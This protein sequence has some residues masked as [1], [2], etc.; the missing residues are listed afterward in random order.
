MVNEKYE[1]LKK[2]SKEYKKEIKSLLKNKT[3]NR[4]KVLLLLSELEEVTN[5]MN[6]IIN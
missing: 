4:S 6:D 3:K 5:S 1:K 2:K